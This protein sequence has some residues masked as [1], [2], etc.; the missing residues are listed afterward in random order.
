MRMER[1]GHSY[2]T[3]RLKPD[4]ELAAL[5]LQAQGDDR[6][7]ETVPPTYMIFLRGETLGLNLFEDLDIPRT[8]A[9]HAGQRYEWFLPVSWDDELE[10]TATVSKITEKDGRRGKIWFADVTYDYC[11]IPSG[12]LAL[13]EV[14]RIVKTSKADG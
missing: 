4:R 10:V 6:K 14:T 1:Q 7:P 12:D 2:P 11:K 13:R 5:Y 9:L 8:Q 3:Y